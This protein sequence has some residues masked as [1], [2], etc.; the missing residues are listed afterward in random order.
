MR[1]MYQGGSLATATDPAPVKSDLLV[2]D[3]IIRAVA[4]SLAVP[5]NTAVVDCSG[6]I[7][8][9]GLFDMLVH[10]R[11]PGREDSETI[12]TG[13]RAALHGGITGVLAMPNT[14][15]PID[16]GGMVRFVRSLAREEAVIPVHTAG[17]ISKQRAGKE[18]AE[19]GDMRDSGALMVTDD[20]HTVEDPQLLL[21]AMQYA[22]D[23]DIVV[24][25]HCATP[26]LDVGGGM[27]DGHMAYRLGVRG[28]PAC[29]EEICMDRDL[30]LAQTAGARVHIQQVTTAHGVEIIR[31][32]KDAGVRVSADVSPHHLLFT[33]EDLATYDTSLKMY[34]P[35]RTEADRLALLDGLRDGTLDCIA[36]DHAP[37]PPF[38]KSRNF[39]AAPFGILGLETALLSI[40]DRLIEP[41]AIGWDLLVRSYVDSPRRVLGLPPVRIA[42]EAPAE[43]VMFDPEKT[44]EVSEAWMQSKSRNTPFLG[45]VLQ[46]HIDCVVRGEETAA[47]VPEQSS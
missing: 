26:A 25:C 32:Y 19:I 33:E 31:R 22:R 15:P 28:L 1:V 6:R 46:G 34:P 47:P 42:E 4:S 9:P 5:E 17:C 16:T 35:L 23:F 29:S 39:T 24:G 7:L 2:E 8:I 12:A 20:G 18:M 41:G 43:F 40:Y 10:M 14:L 21:R 44:T 38:E 30:R 11:Q 36:S 3:G 13:S 27:N 45:T 37:H